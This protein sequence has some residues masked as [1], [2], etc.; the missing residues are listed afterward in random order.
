[1]FRRS[2]CSRTSR[3]IGRRFELYVGTPLSSFQEL[4]MNHP[5]VITGGAGFLGSHLVDAL[6][7]KGHSVIAI[8]NLSHGKLANLSEAMKSPNFKFVEADVCDAAQVGNAFDSA[9]VIV[10]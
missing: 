5:I 3:R 10:Q 8:D 2:S 4:R 9:S 6:L 7:A 1:M